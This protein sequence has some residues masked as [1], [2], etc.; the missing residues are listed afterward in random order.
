[1][2]T[3]RLLKLFKD[4]AT[5]EPDDDEMMYLGADPMETEPPQPAA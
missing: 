1:M 2:W 5:D 3:A 4:A